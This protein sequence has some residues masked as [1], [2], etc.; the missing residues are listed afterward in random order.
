MTALQRRVF[1]AVI[2]R[3]LSGANLWT[4]AANHG[5]RVTLASLY[6]RGLVVRRAWRGVER[7]RDAAHEYRATL[8]VIEAVKRLRTSVN[9]SIPFTMDPT[10]IDL[11]ETS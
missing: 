2:S 11:K 6:Y 5:E 1:A 4:R 3:T 7:Q 10:G 8:Q 9:A